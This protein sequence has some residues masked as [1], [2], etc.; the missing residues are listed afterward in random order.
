M[1]IITPEGGQHVA[2]RAAREFECRTILHG[3][4][5]KFG[6]ISNQRRRMCAVFSAVSGDGEHRDLAVDAESAEIAGFYA[7]CLCRSPYMSPSVGW[8]TRSRSTATTKWRWH[9][10]T[11]QL[12]GLCAIRLCPQA[13][14]S[15]YGLPA[16]PWPRTSATSSNGTTAGIS[17][18]RSRAA[19]ADDLSAKGATGALESL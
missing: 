14:P 12:K 17:R 2:Q 8:G 3:A 18:S 1:A 19:Y 10:E 4:S 5:P 6:N 15:P 9:K 13:V 16:T 7:A 11:L